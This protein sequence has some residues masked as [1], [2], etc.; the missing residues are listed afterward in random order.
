MGV[1]LR[2]LLPLET[3]AILAALAAGRD[4]GMSGV[5]IL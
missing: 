2:E 4:P 1:G 5:V 3:R